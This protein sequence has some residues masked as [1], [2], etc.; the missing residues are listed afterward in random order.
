M[1]PIPLRRWSQFSLRTLFI[2]TTAVAVGCWAHWVALPRWRIYLEQVAFEESI[3][4][5]R[6]DVSPSSGRN[7]IRWAGDVPIKEILFGD[8]DHSPS[9]LSVYV[10]PNAIYLV[11]YVLA[12]D[13]QGVVEAFPSVSVEVF[14]IPP[15]PA[16][17]EA[18]FAGA[19]EAHRLYT[20][21]NAAE[22]RYIMDY[23]HFLS[24]DRKNDYG[25]K[26]ER[27]FADP[28]WRR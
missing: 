24:G 4:S 10:W 7:V 9:E 14:R 12:S 27:V 16:D 17:Y 20:S 1:M 8:A 23:W 22:A 13:V 18:K 25:L 3:R 21:V 15:C 6:V 26:Y 19:R 5:L 2:I 28:A 11:Y